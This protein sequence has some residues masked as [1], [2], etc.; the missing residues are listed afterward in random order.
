VLELASP[1]VSQSSDFLSAS[2]LVLAMVSSIMTVYITSSANHDEPH[3]YQ[4]SDE[5]PEV[6]PK[7]Q[8]E[9][10]PLL[11]QTQGPKKKIMYFAAG[12]GI[13]EV[14]VN[15]ISSRP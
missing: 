2:Q 1:S 12:S 14:K 8:A 7:D 4:H 11:R 10:S 15:I 9:E 3:A 5:I 13:P 6:D